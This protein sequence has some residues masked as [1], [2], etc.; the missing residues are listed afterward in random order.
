MPGINELAAS[1][2]LGG[3]LPMD[4][5]GDTAPRAEAER[6]YIILGPFSSGEDASNFADTENGTVLS[7][8]ELPESL[9]RWL[10]QPN[11]SQ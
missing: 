9:V 3:C 7:S 6:F 5:H 10:D 8:D 4:E 1:G 2:H 11:H